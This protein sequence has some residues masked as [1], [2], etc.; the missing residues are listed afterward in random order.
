MNP[1]EHP[2]SPA[3]ARVP[4]TGTHLPVHLAASAPARLGRVPARLNVVR[5]CSGAR[6]ARLGGVVREHT[7]YLLRA[8]LVV[9]L[10]ATLGAAPMYAQATG[11]TDTATVVSGRAGRP[12]APATASGTNRSAA[13]TSTITGPAGTES[14]AAVHGIVLR[15]AVTGPEDGD[16]LLLIAGSGM[17]LTEW[18]EAL[19]AGLVERGFRVITFDPRDSGFSTHFNEAGPPDWA[20]IFGALAAGT[21]PELPYAVDDMAEDAVGL[22]DALS[23][24]RVH[25]F[26]T[27]MGAT[28]AQ[29][30]AATHPER[31][32]SLTLA[33]ATSGNPVI[34]IPVNPARMMAVPPPPAPTDTAAV[35]ARQIALWKALASPE[36]PIDEAEL[37]ARV[38]AS[39]ARAYD[40]VAAERQ[41]AAALAAGDRREQLRTIRVPTVV[42]HGADDP[43]IPVDA[44]RE[45]ASLIPDAELRIIPG[46]G[47]DM[48][49]TVVPRIVDS[50][51]S[52][53]ARAARVDERG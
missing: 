39:I 18:P 24:E 48:P 10:P 23:L 6:P 25:L 8:G 30:I 14:D 32:L 2:R 45:V 26:G 28:I 52:A 53:A 35:I 29:I 22:L 44:G 40:P 36:S 41:G 13:P 31:T 4:T 42:I 15:Y 12:A 46:M 43:L 20:A 16:P 1:V 49:D 33:M 19:I 47:H 38:E 17:Q 11:A 3:A 34:R 5:T 21:T 37:R 51:T 7:R 9:A 50:I 27:S